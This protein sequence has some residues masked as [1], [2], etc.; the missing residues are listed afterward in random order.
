MVW[1]HEVVGSSPTAPI[2]LVRGGRQFPPLSRWRIRQRTLMVDKSACP[3]R[4]V[5]GNRGRPD[6]TSGPPRIAPV[7]QLNKGSVLL[8]R[9]RACSSIG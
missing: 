4:K 1:D 3:E 7:V 6:A 2:V 8:D 9:R 5:R